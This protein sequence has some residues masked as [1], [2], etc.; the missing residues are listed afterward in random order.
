M[1]DTRTEYDLAEVEKLA[2]SG[3]LFAVLDACDEPD[4]PPKVAELGPEAGVCLY[5]G[6]AEEDYW[7]IAPYLVRVYPPLLEW[8]SSHIAASPWGIL[9]VSDASLA[10]LRLHF[11]RLLFVAAPTGEQ[12]YFRFYDPRVLQALAGTCSSEQAAE[13]CGPIHQLLCPAPGSVSFR[14]LTRDSFASAAS[15]VPG[16]DAPGPAQSPVRH[17]IR[18]R[19]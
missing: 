19:L 18:V 13:L 11:K 5:G 9:A 17:S 15:T 1:T 4:I 6:T 12:W 10:E 8:I 16:S 7:A 14:L 3:R 2:A